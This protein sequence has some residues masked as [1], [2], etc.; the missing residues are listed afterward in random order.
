MMI[1]E[2]ITSNLLELV[3]LFIPLPVLPHLFLLHYSSQ[4]S[5]LENKQVQSPVSEYKENPVLQILTNFKKN[6]KNI[7]SSR[8]HV[9]CLFTILLALTM[10]KPLIPD[11]LAS[12]IPIYWLLFFLLANVHHILVLNIKSKEPNWVI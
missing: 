9:N 5:N 10:T 12:M 3:L 1:K 6:F 2:G 11:N 8:N 7:F 4:A